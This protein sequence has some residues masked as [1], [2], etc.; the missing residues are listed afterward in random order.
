[1]LGS[2]FSG[3]ARPAAIYIKIEIVQV[4]QRNVGGQ[5]IR[6]GIREE[7]VGGVG[8]G[9]LGAVQCRVP[10]GNICKALPLEPCGV[11]SVCAV[12]GSP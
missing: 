10:S 11:P 9:G 12:W 1:M 4:R 5:C 6:A 8:G 7:F 3:P 2:F